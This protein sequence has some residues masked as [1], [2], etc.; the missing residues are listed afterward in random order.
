MKQV[1]RVFWNMGEGRLRAPFRILVYFVLWILL[2]RLLDWM[3]IPPL[4]NLWIAQGGTNVTWVAHGI[5]FALYFVD[6]ILVTYFCAHAIDRRST[7]QLGMQLDRAWWIELLAGLALGAVLMS[8]IFLLAWLLGWIQINTLF[9]VL[10]PDIPF[11]VAILGALFVFVV[12]G[13]TEELMFR[14]YVLRNCAEGIRGVGIAPR[15][16]VIGGWLL[17]SALFGAFHVLN[18]NANWISTINLTLAGMMLGLPM[19]LTGRLGMSIGL[20]I[21]WNFVQGNIYGFPVS[22]NDFS[23]VTVFETLTSGPDLWTGGRFGPEAGLIGVFAILAGSAL[24][25][26]WLRGRTGRRGIDESLAIY[27]PRAVSREP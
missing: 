22:G 9:A 11:V 24:I 25:V 4:T 3:L 15:T 14:G 5:H 13:V 10:A 23:R 8:L 7:R 12:I 6:V 21:A 27:Q 2:S 18:P 20:H 1:Q 16:A 17:S 19:V 26:W